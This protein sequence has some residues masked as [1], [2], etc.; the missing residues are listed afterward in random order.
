MKLLILG[1]TAEAK[2][3]AKSLLKKNVPL[4]YSIAGLVRH[5]D[6]NCEIISGG[7]TRFGGLN[8]YIKQQRITAILDVTHPYAVKMSATAMQCALPYWRFERPAWQP[9]ADDNWIEFNGN[10]DLLALLQDKR[11]VMFTTGQID[12]TLTN[13]LP[14][15]QKQLLRTAIKPTVDLSMDMKWIQAIGPFDLTDELDLMNDHCIDALVSK[16]SGGAATQAKLV[17]ARVLGIPVYMKKRP[18]LIKAT[19]TFNDLIACERFVLAH[20]AQD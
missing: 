20:L 4:V 3:L 16:N 9:T 19:N 7:F 12:Q 2:Q 13:G 5:P 8:N 17:A 18:E 15:G 1:G 11:S 10:S 6:L 14:Q